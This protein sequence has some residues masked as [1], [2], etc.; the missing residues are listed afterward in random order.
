MKAGQKGSC[1]LTRTAVK[2]DLGATA[3]EFWMSSPL[4]IIEKLGMLLPAPE[5]G[6]G[7]RLL[8]QLF[9]KTGALYWASGNL[10]YM[11]TRTHKQRHFVHRTGF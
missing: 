5:P 7:H 6:R 3:Q 2:Q 10:A 11:Y 9:S 8:L 4:A 1:P